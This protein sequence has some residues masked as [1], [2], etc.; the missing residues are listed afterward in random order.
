LIKPSSLGFIAI[1]SL[2]IGIHITGLRP[3]SFL[4]LIAVGYPAS[5][6]SSSSL[7]DIFS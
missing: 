5:W 7:P 6:L 3:H 4:R 1:R 2:F